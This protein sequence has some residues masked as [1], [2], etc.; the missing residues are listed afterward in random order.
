MRFTTALHGVTW[1]LQLLAFPAV[2]LFFMNLSPMATALSFRYFDFFSVR[3]AETLL[4]DFQKRAEASRGGNDG[5]SEASHEGRVDGDMAQAIDKTPRGS[6]LK[7]N[8]QRGLELVQGAIGTQI[9]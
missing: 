7:Q 3:Y 9:P 5:I 1:R 8:T 4:G 2:Q 6:K